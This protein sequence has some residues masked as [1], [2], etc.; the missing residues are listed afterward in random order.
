MLFGNQPHG[1]KIKTVPSKVSSGRPIFPVSNFIIDPI[2]SCQC[3][4]STAEYP[5]ELKDDRSKTDQVIRGL[6]KAE[7][8]VVSNCYTS[9]G[10]QNGRVVTLT[11]IVSSDD[12]F[13]DVTIFSDSSVHRIIIVIEYCVFPLEIQ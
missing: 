8:R 6:E 3:D 12:S 1:I 4:K 9:H 7:I 11:A 2:D 5:I 13:R 10:I